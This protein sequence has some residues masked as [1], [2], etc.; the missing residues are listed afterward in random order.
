MGVDVLKQ[1]RDRLAAD[2]L[3]QQAQRAARGEVPV[4]AVTAKAYAYTKPVPDDLWIKCPTCEG[5]MFR[6]AFEKNLQ[7]CHVCGHHYRLD[8]RQRLAQIVDEG[9]FEEFDANMTSLNPI[10]F[11]GYPEKL[12]QLQQ[13]TGLKDAVVTG[14]GKIHG[15]ECLVAI[16]DNRFM[17]GSMG[18]VV[19]EKITRVFEKGM[20]LK[21]PVLTF[22]VSGGARMQEGIV[23]LMQ[24]AKTSAAVGR[25]QN[26]GG[27][28]ISIMTDPTTGGVTASFASLGDIIISEP[29]TLIGFAGRRVIEGTIAEAL[30]DDFQR[31]EFLLEHGFLDLIVPRNQLKETLATLL[32]IH[33]PTAAEGSFEILDNAR[34]AMESA[35]AAVA[36][37]T[38][39][40]SARL[41][42][43]R[44]R[45]R[46]V[47]TDYLP[48]VFDLAIELHGDRGFADDAAL[49]CGLASLSGQPVTLIAHRKGRKIEENTKANFGMPHPEGY[50]K[51]L[52]LMKQAEK[53]NRPIICMIDTSG[54]Y[55]GVGAEERGQGEAIARNLLE[56]A[57]LNVP[58]L[59]V[60]M[61]EGGSGGALAIGVGDELA[62]LSNALYS[63]ISPRGFASL[64]WKDHTREREAADSIK[65]TAEDLTRLGICDYTI[66]EPGAGAHTNLSE[67]AENL[68]TYLK[69]ALARQLK[70]PA[71]SRLD[72]RYQKFR[73][74]GS[75]SE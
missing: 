32:A 20:A 71:S 3:H 51:A 18:S 39:S 72:N 16:M 43:I 41:D 46:P 29:G 52:R 40:G 64:L 24:M 8:S 63:V 42:I 11:K 66:A 5:V 12:K 31:A 55:C 75:F 2:T 6:E 70:V 68:Q 37:N 45:Q 14:R 27:L 21:L 59:C 34:V 10:E 47:I 23:S 7:V 44:Q 60:V 73:K 38:L 56:M 36:I 35:T 26:A 13:Q 48:L 61:G 1:M 62:M 19:G 53:F 22:S 65:I 74:I 50:R 25:F 58:I 28:Y 9:S 54:A 69:A 49:Y 67:M 30:P 4:D 17:M 33:H 57:G 15:Q